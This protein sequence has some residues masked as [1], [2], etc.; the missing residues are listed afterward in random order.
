MADLL[1]SNRVHKPKNNVRD[2][3]PGSDRQFL[4]RTDFWFFVP[5]GEVG[6]N[7]LQTFSD[8]W[9]RIPQ[10]VRYSMM[11]YWLSPHRQLPP[12][13][14]GPPVV[15]LANEWQERGDSLS[16][17]YDS[18]YYFFHESTVAIMP[19]YVLEE[20]IAHRVCQGLQEHEQD[21]YCTAARST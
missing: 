17:Q 2:E 7:F 8:V 9:F 10:R 12:T 5:N 14:D 21:Q 11:H 15:T 18:R 19:D 4:P 1:R 16:H 3:R 13:G 20:L 6:D